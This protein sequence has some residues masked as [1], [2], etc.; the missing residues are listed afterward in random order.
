MNMHRWNRQ[1]LMLLLLVMLRQRH[2]SIWLETIMMMRVHL[3]GSHGLSAQRAR[4][5]KSRSLKG[6]QLEV[7]PS[8]APW[9][10]VHKFSK[11]WHWL[12]ES[13][14]FAV[15]PIQ[16]R[17]FTANHASLKFLHVQTKRMIWNGNWIWMGKTGVMW[18]SKPEQWP[19]LKADICT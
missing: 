13:S 5:T 10:T 2:L 4:K 15:R 18:Q 1:F 6:P 7:G 14:F 17:L 12:P 19:Q 16:Q 9:L 8:G 3:R 11:V